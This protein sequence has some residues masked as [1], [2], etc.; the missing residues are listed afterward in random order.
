MSKAE[1]LLEAEY[2]RKLFTRRVLPHY[3]DFSAIKEIRIRPYKKLIWSETYHLVIKYSVIFL[4]HDGR[5]VSLPI[6]ATAHS[7]ED[8]ENVFLTL[9]YLWDHHLSDEQIRLPRPLFYDPELRATFYRAVEGQNLLQAIKNQDWVAVEAGTRKAAVLFA[10]IHSLPLEGD[11][12]FNRANGR[13]ATVI[14]GA[15]FVITE[16]GYRFSGRYQSQVK[17]AYER[18]IAREDDFFNRTSQRWLIHGDAHPEN[19]ILPANDKIG[20]IDFTDF[21]RAD[22]AR[23]LGAFGQQLEYKIATKGADSARA[24]ELKE[25]FWEEYFKAA[26]LKL[27]QD[28]RQRIDLYYNFTIL[29]T[30]IY[31]LLKYDCDPVRGQNLLDSL[32]SDFK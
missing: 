23:D 15:E 19:I 17:A 12:G 4:D 1:L 11:Y 21:C 27:D 8:R 28:L 13:I 29:R 22:F 26:G 20:I 9:S 10:K 18:L 16:L 6:V 14:P 25:L 24:S 7:N 32:S 30:A 2:L 5:E 3:P 31:W